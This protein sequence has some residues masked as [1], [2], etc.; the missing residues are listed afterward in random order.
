[1]QIDISSCI[2]V[3]AARRRCQR[4]QKSAALFAIN[5]IVKVQYMDDGKKARGERWCSASIFA[6]MGQFILRLIHGYCYA[7][8]NT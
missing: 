7:Y 8:T 4:M 5:I 2:F 6:W 1:M 3:C